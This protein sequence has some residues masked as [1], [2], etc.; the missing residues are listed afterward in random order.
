MIDQQAHALLWDPAMGGGFEECEFPGMGFAVPGGVTPEV[1]RDG[2][3]AKQT[4]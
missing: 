2:V 1:P 3:I 4:V